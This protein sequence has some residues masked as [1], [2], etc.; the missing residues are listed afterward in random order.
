MQITQEQYEKIAK[1]LP[2]Q[3]GNV[4]M[5]NFLSPENV[6]ETSLLVQGHGG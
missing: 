3:G 2:T 1:Y 6:Q 4:S 5:T